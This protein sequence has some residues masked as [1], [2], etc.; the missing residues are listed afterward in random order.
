MNGMHGAVED[1]LTMRRALGFKLA[2]HGRHPDLV[3]GQAFRGARVRPLPAHPRS[4]YRGATGRPA[5]LPAATRSVCPR[6]K[7]TGRS[8]LMSAAT[9]LGSTPWKIPALARISSTLPS[10]ALG[11]TAHGFRGRHRPRKPLKQ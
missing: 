6:G 2:D 3:R 7:S 10:Y 9:A 5:D 4:G 8:C 11:P 1:Y